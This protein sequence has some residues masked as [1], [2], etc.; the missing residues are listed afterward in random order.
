MSTEERFRRPDS[1]LVILF[2]LA[3]LIDRLAGYRPPPIKGRLVTFTGLLV[4]FLTFSYD[5]FSTLR[6][7]GG[8]LSAEPFGFLFL[9]ACLGY[10]VSNEWLR[11][12]LSGF[13]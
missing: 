6:I 9:M 8:H 7:T 11:T 12:R 4:F 5:R 2:P 13:H 3:L 1:L 10:I